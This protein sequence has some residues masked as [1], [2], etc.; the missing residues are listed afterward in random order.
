M[1]FGIGRFGYVGEKDVGMKVYTTINEFILM[2]YLMHC[3][4]MSGFT[5]AL[6]GRINCFRSFTVNMSPKVAVFWNGNL[7]REWKE[8][9]PNCD[10]WIDKCE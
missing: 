6:V 3:T 5:P 8:T 10:D 7:W 1:I 9:F 4:Y 2:L